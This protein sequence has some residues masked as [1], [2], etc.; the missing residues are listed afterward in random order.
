MDLGL[1]DGQNVQL[2]VRVRSRPAGT[3]ERGSYAI[4]AQ[5]DGWD[6]QGEAGEIKLEGE[7]QSPLSATPLPAAV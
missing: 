3:V 1:G 2:I 4:R 7:G 6:A 5:F